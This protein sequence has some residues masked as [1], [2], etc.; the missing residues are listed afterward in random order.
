[1]LPSLKVLT[2]EMTKSS[3]F[4]VEHL[5][6]IGPHYART[7]REWRLRFEQNWDFIRNLG[8]DERFR[9]I[10]NYYF[11]YCEAGFEQR[12]T[13]NYQLLLARAGR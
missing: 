3:D 11:C 12:V 9:R 8:F 5:E 6:N 1:M 2:R 10:W 13:D 7:L 4:V